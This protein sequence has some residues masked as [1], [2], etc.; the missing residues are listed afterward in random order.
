[1]SG[2]TAEA[3]ARAGAKTFSQGCAWWF[4]EWPRAKGR[5]AMKSGV[6]GGLAQDG[7]WGV[8]SLEDHC[9]DS[10]ERGTLCFEQRCVS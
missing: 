8:S 10:A 5:V 9:K 1:M 3:T 7:A 2:R 6:A 4:E